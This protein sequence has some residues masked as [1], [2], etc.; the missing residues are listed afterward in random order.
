MDLEGCPDSFPPDEKSKS[1]QGDYFE[2]SADGKID[3]WEH[4]E[5]TAYG[6]RTTRRTAWDTYVDD[7]DE[8]GRL[9][10]QIQYNNGI[11]SKMEEYTYN[12]D[13]EKAS[14]HL[15]YYDYYEWSH[16][17]KYYDYD[18][19]GRLASV[20]T[21]TRGQ[22]N[23]TEKYVY[24]E[25]GS[26]KMYYTYK[27]NL[28]YRQDGT[29]AWYDRYGN[30]L[31]QIHYSDGSI[32]VEEKHDYELN[33]N[34]KI[35]RDTYHA[36][37]YHEYGTQI[38]DQV[39][40]NHYTD[41]G[42]V[43][44][45]TV[46]G[47]GYTSV[48]A[49]LRNDAGAVVYQYDRQEY[50]S[51]SLSDYVTER[52]YDI[53]PNGGQICSRTYEYSSSTGIRTPREIRFVIDEGERGSR[54][55]LHP[56]PVT[57]GA[58]ADTF[59][60]E[61]LQYS[62][63]HMTRGD[64][65]R[66]PY[67][68]QVSDCMYDS[69]AP[70]EL[71]GR[72]GTLRFIFGG[73]TSN[74]L[75]GIWWIC[76]DRDTKA[77][78]LIYELQEA[79][80]RWENDSTAEGQWNMLGIRTKEGSM[81]SGKVILTDASYGDDPVFCVA[82]TFLWNEPEDGLI[83]PWQTDEYTPERSGISSGTPAVSATP[84]PVPEPV[85]ETEAEA[86]PEAEPEAEPG[87]EPET[88]PD[89][90]LYPESEQADPAIMTENEAAAWT[91]CWMT[92]DDSKGELVITSNGDGTLHMKI[93]FLRTFDMEADLMRLDGSHCSFETT[94]GHYS[95]F[96]TQ[97]EDGTLL[98]SVAGGM[99]MEDDENELYYF[100]R[101]HE[102]VFRPAD[103]SDL[104]YESP[105]DAPEEDADWAG[106]WTAHYGELTSELRIIRGTGGG[107]IMQI[108]FST[109]Y[110]IA[111]QLEKTDSRTM[112]FVTDDFS[113]MLT[114]NRKK[115][116]IVMSEI[117]S[118]SDDVYRWLDAVGGVV[119]YQAEEPAAA[120]P[121]VQSE[122]VSVP[123]EAQEQ[124]PQYDAAG[125]TLVP[126]PGRTGCMQV[127]VALVNASSYIV[128]KDPSAYIP[129]RMIDGEQTT[130]FQFSTKDS[131]LGNAYLFFEFEVPSAVDELWIKNGYWKKSDGKDQYLRNCRVKSMT[132]EFRC[133]GQDGY[134][135]P[136]TAALDDDTERKDWT[137]IP[138]GHR[139]G[140]TGIR[141]RI[142]DIYQG[143]KFKYDVCISEIM[144]VKRTD[145][146]E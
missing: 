114:L 87:P 45:K 116:A 44:R 1:R 51:G 17:W 131:P 120:V 70:V 96:L 23:I 77:A 115:H 79:G 9:I 67:M 135:D 83:M 64:I 134:R 54:R 119:E 94:Y 140:V 2:F 68:K 3:S 89:D 126:V 102:F 69:T 37:Y 141:I 11:I 61:D 136:L 101:D 113:A 5:R 118:M 100:F 30:P 84:E 145:I 85:P 24:A 88:E 130:A 65:S 111:G 71:Y 98:F 63:R 66:L 31:H 43:D 129:F 74:R 97:D 122:P 109:G 125:E 40:E 21:N 19:S 12:T 50:D 57:Q 48:T 4:D 20:R 59:S 104:W 10:R 6:R 15:V 76:R 99:S 27:T 47:D 72:N 38:I 108:R 123:E 41:S 138:L 14:Y 127:P 62:L 91:G 39:T 75:Q 73:G 80:V 36:A 46:T 60:L 124:V 92:G 34:G 28:D 143:S 103:Y 142:D 144:F 35:I 13:G 107:Y 16:S 18:A 49:Y 93:F 81:D 132:V 56:F 112:D 137:V 128:G 106:E 133:A 8:S 42:W 53:G 52:E 110:A 7:Y 58:A 25:D 22:E 121:A 82:F 139:T 29:E 55:G 95:G 78:E 26:Y 33:E 146:G 90:E 117:G 32:L 105:A 86:D